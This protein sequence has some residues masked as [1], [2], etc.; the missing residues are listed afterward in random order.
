[1]GFNSVGQYTASH[2]VWDH[3]GNIIPAVEMSEGFR[4]AINFKVAS[5]LP[6]QL[7]DK[8]AEDWWVLMPGKGVALDNDGCIIPAGYGVSGASVVYTADDVTAGTIDIRTGVAL[9]AAATFAISTVDGSSQNFMGR[10][11]VSGV[12]SQWCGIA[13]YAYFQW[14]GDGSADDDGF[15]P[16]A[17]KQYN[18]NKQHGVA[19]NCD[20]MIEVPLVPALHAAESVSFSAPGADCISEGTLAHTPVAKNTMRT[21]FTF[22]DGGSDDHDLFLYEKDALADLATTG[23]WFV[24]LATGVVS[25]YSGTTTPTGVTIAYYHYATAPTGSSVSRFACALGT[26]NPGDFVKFNVDS[27]YVKADPASDTFEKICGQVLGFDTYPKDALE[28]VRTAF[29]SIGST[30]TGSLPGYAGQ[31][32]QMPGSATGGVSD[33]IHYA[34]AADKVVFINL[35]GR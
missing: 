6:V 21:E 24:N 5:W 28:K 33:K 13:P 1:M 4:P 10:S 22:A 3:V 19:I 35:I 7:F 14:S 34:G 15:N 18:Y 27:N 25:V 32:D 23:D 9:T 31:M 29:A 20:Y 8:Y 17:Y 11:G 26:L 16:I 2:K 12:F 30:A